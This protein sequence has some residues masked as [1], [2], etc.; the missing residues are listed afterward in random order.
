MMGLRPTVF[1]VDDDASFLTSITR[2]L[3]ASGYPTAS[4]L[5]AA[6]FLAQLSPQTRG[7]VLTDLKMPVMNGLALQEV[8]A[9]SE[10]PLPIVFLTG[11]GDIPVSVK[12]MRQGAEDF[13]TKTAPKEALLA[14]IDRALAR[15]ASES[16]ERATR[17]TLQARFEAL[18]RRERQV[19]AHVLRGRLNKQ[20]AADFG[21]DERS[22]KRHRSSVMA[23]LG[24]KSVTELTQ[25]A[26]T[27][28]IM[29]GSEWQWLD[30]DPPI[31]SNLPASLRL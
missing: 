30:D 9:Q 10:N 29:S 24:V 25:L 20:I 7:C 23:K 11:H 13:L 28:G 14:A 31:T 12:A 3:R 26:I 18:T 5:S 1:V 15:D 21:I 2:L 27:A 16:H 4:F 6:E 8:L 17:L 22:V 19:L